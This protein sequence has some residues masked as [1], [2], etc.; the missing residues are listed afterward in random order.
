MI[1]FN[2]PSVRGF[3]LKFGYVYTIRKKRKKVGYDYAAHGCWH[4]GQV[5]KIGKVYINLVREVNTVE[6]VIG[7]VENSGLCDPFI[8]ISYQRFTVANKWI[9]LAKKLSGDELC[10]YRVQL[11]E[12]CQS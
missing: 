1:W 3:L 4:K 8:N 11:M 10:L 5:H 9:E 12:R 7:H 6:D 2:I